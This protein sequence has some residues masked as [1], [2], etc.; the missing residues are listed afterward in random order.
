MDEELP[1]KPED[2]TIAKHRQIDKVGVERLLRLPH[3]VTDFASKRVGEFVQDWGNELEA[4]YRDWQREHPT[5]T[6]HT[7]RPGSSAQQDSLEPKKRPK[8]TDQGSGLGNEEVRRCYHNKTMGKVS[9]DA[10]SPC[11]RRITTDIWL[12]TAYRRCPTR[13][14]ARQ[15]SRWPRQKARAYREG[16]RLLEPNRLTAPFLFLYRLNQ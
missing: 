14:A 8:A 11:R 3:H 4:Q 15:R 12:G 10:A 13:V 2:K 1:D 5:I 9:Q 7:K 16:V 6:I